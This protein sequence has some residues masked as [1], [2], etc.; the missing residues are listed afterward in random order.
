MTKSNSP[1]HSAY[2]IFSIVTSLLLYSVI[3]FTFLL[4]NFL[5]S[6][7]LII[8]AFSPNSLVVTLNFKSTQTIS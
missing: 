6:L 8:S 1:V 3:I 4:V 5:I 2:S 7:T